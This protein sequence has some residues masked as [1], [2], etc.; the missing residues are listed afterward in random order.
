MM[1]VNGVAS[2]QFKT[3]SYNIVWSPVDI[4]KP[5]LLQK[6]IHEM[7]AMKKTV[8]LNS[9]YSQEL[10][11]ILFH[12]CC[13]STGQLQPTLTGSQ[14]VLILSS[15]TMI[16]VIMTRPRHTSFSDQTQDYHFTNTSMIFADINITGKVIHRKELLLN[17][18][19]HL[20]SIA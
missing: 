7:A 15:P 17:G 2:W 5:W 20:Q 10:F 14:E 8:P 3:R 12:V 18:R 13:V 4:C 11:S 16:A 19:M 9:H 6:M 1:V